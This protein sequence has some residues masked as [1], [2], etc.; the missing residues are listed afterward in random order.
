MRYEHLSDEEVLSTVTRLRVLCRAHNQYEAEKTFGR[1]HIEKKVAERRAA[2][3]P[4]SDPEIAPPTANDPAG[5]PKIARPRVGS[6]MPSTTSPA[7]ATLKSALV[8]LGFRT[9][10][11]DTA[12]STFSDE[13]WARP[14][15]QLLRDALGRLTP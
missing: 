3:D 8:G 10:E 14:I 15:E 1:A 6:A 13:H 5:D 9:K 11:V 12:I 2:N 4:A 7:H